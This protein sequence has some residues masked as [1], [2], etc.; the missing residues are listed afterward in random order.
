MAALYSLH[1]DR[2]PVVQARR[3]GPVPRSVA[4]LAR[5]RR[6]RREREARRAE[7]NSVRE[8][9]RLLRALRDSALADIAQPDSVLA[10]RL[11]ERA[12]ET[13]DDL[14][15]RL[16]TLEARARQLAYL[17]GDLWHVSAFWF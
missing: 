15:E 12:G 10:V 11:R 17:L 5:V 14:T 9:V 8:D 7:M 2:P 13:V 6:E 4:S 16:K 3:Y 1:A